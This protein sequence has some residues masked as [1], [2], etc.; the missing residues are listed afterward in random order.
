[1]RGH[2]T[3]EAMRRRNQKPAGFVDVLLEARPKRGDWAT[4]EFCRDRLF[5]EPDDTI[6]R[7]DLRFLTGCQVWVSGEDIARVRELFGA[8]QDHGAARVIAHHHVPAAEKGA[9]EL[10]EILDTEGILTW[11][12]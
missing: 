3:Y 5:V 7:L 11:Q 12:A 1:M 9:F 4:Q 8:I 10:R 6:A 2:E